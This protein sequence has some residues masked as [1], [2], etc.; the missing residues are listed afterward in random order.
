[1]ARLRDPDG[2]C[3]WDLEQDFASIAPYTIEEA[4]E[5]ADAIERGDMEELKDE[6]GDLLLQIVF[7]ARMAEEAGLF[8]F[9]DV[10]EAISAKMI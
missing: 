8:A 9:D 2:G 3:P 10:A 6:L 7:H 5:V 4:Y 1:M